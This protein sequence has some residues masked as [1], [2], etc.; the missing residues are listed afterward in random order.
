MKST[1]NDSASK[2]LYT[3][4]YFNQLQHFRLQ[5]ISQII[6]RNLSTIAEQLFQTVFCIK[7]RIIQGALNVLTRQNRSL[8]VV[9][10]MES[11]ANNS[12]AFEECVNYIQ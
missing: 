5:T 3:V 8:S 11:L 2:C 12:K 7:P 4:L 6:P 9:E 10:E 1:T